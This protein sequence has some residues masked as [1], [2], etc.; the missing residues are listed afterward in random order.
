MSELVERAKAFALEAHKGQN[1]NNRAETPMMEHVS[2]VASLVEQSGGSKEEVVAAWL[3]DV[4][5]DTH[6]VIQDI[7]DNFGEEVTSIVFG[8]TDLP[9][10]RNLHT[11]ERKA[12]QARRI[13]CLNDSVKRVK[14]ADQI[15]NVRSTAVDPPVQ[16]SRQRCFYYI[17]GARQVIEECLGISSFLEDEFCKAYNAAK[18]VHGESTTDAS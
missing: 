7:F 18:L 13:R 9:E 17:E 2:E 1:R 11:R 4:V 15:S 12:A 6:S 3:H 8:L 14:L 16:W 5:E 10:F